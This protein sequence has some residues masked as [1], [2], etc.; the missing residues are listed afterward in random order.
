MNVARALARTT[1]ENAN[2]RDKSSR[3]TNLIA[4]TEPKQTRSAKEQQEKEH[5]L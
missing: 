2:K 4:D 5:E 3:N 1:T